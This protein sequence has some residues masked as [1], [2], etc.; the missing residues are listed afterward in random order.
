MDAN[1]GYEFTI[2]QLCRFV[3]STRRSGYQFSRLV[4][5]GGE[6]LLWSNLVEGVTIL[7]GS[8]LFGEIAMH[9]NLA[10][11]N[12]DELITAVLP[13]VTLRISRYDWNEDLVAKACAKFELPKPR[14]KSHYPMPTAPQP[15]SLPAICQCK[16][17]NVFGDRVDICSPYRTIGIDTETAGVSTG[18]SVNYLDRLDEDRRTSQ[19]TC[20][21]CV[22][23]PKVVGTARGMGRV[24]RFGRNVREFVRKAI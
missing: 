20:A 7:H 3:N 5:S 19:P 12:A 22:A 10:A 17:L 8:K 1:K 24:I 18:M 14:K 16:R 9:T 13:Y 4:L 23:N 2:A 11:P 15:A 6:P 21:M